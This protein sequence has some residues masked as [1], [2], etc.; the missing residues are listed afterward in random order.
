MI[1]SRTIA[2]RRMAAGATPSWF[3]AWG[4][5]MADAVLFFGIAGFS[6]PF[7]VGGLADSQGAWVYAALFAIYF[8]PMQIVLITSAMWAA[9]SRWVDEV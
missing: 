9:Q 6:A 5:V 7:I 4:L 1:L 3:E 8:I 2:R